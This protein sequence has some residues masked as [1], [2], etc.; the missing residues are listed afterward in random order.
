M[1]GTQNQ[2]QNNTYLLRI[3]L[4]GE[5]IMNTTIKI[6]FVEIISITNN[7]NRIGICLHRY[8]CENRL[9]PMCVIFP[10]FCSVTSLVKRYGKMLLCNDLINNPFYIYILYIWNKRTKIKSKEMKTERREEK[11]WTLNGTSFFHAK[12]HTRAHAYARTFWFI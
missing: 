6:I 7:P 8:V 10:N 11:K 1:N 3:H 2:S 5:G 9:K 12:T 4:N